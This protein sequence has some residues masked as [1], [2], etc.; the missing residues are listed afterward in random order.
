VRT[1]F[2]SLS[3]PNPIMRRYFLLLSLAVALM[4]TT[5]CARYVLQLTNGR[6][7]DAHSRPR[8]VDGVYHFKDGSG[9]PTSISASRV[10]VIE[11]R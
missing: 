4:A 2:F 6:V 10:T 8:L 7:V 9:Q 5:G 1:K 3:N 11:Q